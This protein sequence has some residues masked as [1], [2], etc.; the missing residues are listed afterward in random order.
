MLFQMAKFHSFLWL[1]NI[2]SYTQTQ[3]TFFI[4]L[5]VNGHLGWFHIL[6]I[7]NYTAVNTGGMYLFKL[8]FS[9]SLEVELLDHM[10][11]LFLVLF[12]HLHTV[13]HS[14]CSN[15]QSNQQCT[16]IPFSPHLLSSLSTFVVCRL[17]A[18]ATLTG[19]RWYLIVSDFHFP[20]D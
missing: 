12:R 13:F 18:M 4:H 15:L 16:R 8:V 2:L 9:L 5:S 19:I 11:V 17:L 7:I 20:D 10:V 14:G 1:S 3:C 6:A